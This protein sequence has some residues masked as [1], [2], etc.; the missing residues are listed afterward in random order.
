MAAPHKGFKDE[1]GENK[2][3]LSCGTRF[4]VYRFAIY[5]DGFQ[6]FK[7][8]TDTSSVA[9]C[10]LLPLGLSCENRKGPGATRPITI[11]SS[12]YH[13]ADH[14]N[15]LNLLWED[16]CSAAATGIDG[17]DPYGR[18]V[19]IFLDPVTFY[20]DYPAVSACTGV[21]GHT[22]N[23]FC[24]HCGVIQSRN[25]RSPDILSNNM[26]HSRRISLIRTDARRKAL[27]SIRT[28]KAIYNQLGIKLV[29]SETEK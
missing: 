14:Y 5:M 15:A 23:A 20:G 29:E 10:Y 2:G 16:I 18:R 17:V 11:A 28:Q 22:A 27:L 12:S 8:N 26:H 13:G 9:G 4:V 21:L 3:I 25:L 19:R 1:G 24:T 7:S 6:Q